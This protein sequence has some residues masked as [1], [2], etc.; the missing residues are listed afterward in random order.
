[1]KKIILII[2]LTITLIA[3]AVYF[4]PSLK[5]D[6]VPRGNEVPQSADEERDMVNQSTQKQEETEEKSEIT[7]IIREGE[8]R[9]AKIG[10][11]QHKIKIAAISSDD[12]AMID[13]DGEIEG[14]MKN[15]ESVF[16][17]DLSVVITDVVYS[18]KTGTL[19]QVT[20]FI[21]KRL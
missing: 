3:L 6:V 21:K 16:F 4:L 7:L 5:P 20:L 11:I 12:Q 2:T 1:M 13:I 18:P 19:S 8:T 15:E 17:D 10:G 14:L 9:Y